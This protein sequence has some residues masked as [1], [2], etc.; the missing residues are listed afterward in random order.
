MKRFAGLFAFAYLFVVFAGGALAAAQRQHWSVQ[1]AN[2]AM[3]RWPAGSSS[4]A[5]LPAG[6]GALLDAIQ[7]VWLNSVDRPDYAY[8]KRTVDPFIGPGGSFQSNG[9]PLAEVQLGRSLLLL[10]GVSLNKRYFNAATALYNQLQ[11]QPPATPEEM[12]ESG[13]FRAEY[14]LT[15]DHPEAFAGITE[16]FARMQEAVR[17]G[18]GQTGA[19]N[20]GWARTM[21]WYVA[22]LA[23]TIP[24]F[25]EDDPGRKQLIAILNQDAAIVARYQDT[26]TGLWNQMLDKP[27]AK[28]SAPDATASSLFVYALAKGV[29]LGYLPER[30]GV[31]SERGY[32]S[33]VSQ[34]AS[35]GS[36]GA[37]TLA[38]T[39]APSNP[40]GFGAFILASTEAEHIQSA[41]LGRGDTV[42]VD[43]W[44]NSQQLT[45]PTGRK[46]YFHYKWDD[47]ADPGYSLWGRIFRNFGARTTTLY[48]EPTAENLRQAQVYIIASPDN[49]EKNPQAHFANAEDAAQIAKWV[50]SGGVL[51]IMEN[52]TSFADLTHFNVISEKYGIHFNSVLRMH[53][54]GTDW[55]MGKFQLDGNGPIFHHPHTVYVKDVCTISVKPPAV[56]VY[57]HDGD[58]F[59]AVAKYGKGT[60]YAMVDPWFYN[61]YTNGLKLP[62]MYD[63]YGAGIELARWILD[64]VPKQTARETATAGR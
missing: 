34:F 12:A 40:A 29:R 7:A 10:Y 3:A 46:V 57:T 11:S 53:V 52:D 18:K 37:V 25:P 23:D 1:A 62:A 6:E 45:D 30:Y 50:K 2:S 28:A 36:N 9:H 32:R 47:Q 5:G 61:E 63:N 54:V 14:A 21:G 59:M 56:P 26:K 19:A 44:F 13:P 42:M 64:Q 20:S 15:F 17:G 33:I 58:I 41:K 31:V 49:L 55:S 51:V 27:G 24:Y 48:A 16:Q 38:G 22:A 8:I 39:G 4:A 60:V 35:A 43:G